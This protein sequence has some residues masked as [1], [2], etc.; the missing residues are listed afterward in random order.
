MI[1]DECLSNSQIHTST[2]GVYNL[3][4]LL[5]KPVDILFRVVFAEGQPDGAGVGRKV[6]FI[7]H[8]G[9]DAGAAGASAATTHGDAVDVEIE[10]QHVVVFDA[11]DGEAQYLVQAV[12]QIAAQAVKS[13]P[14]KTAFD[15]LHRVGFQIAQIG[16]FFMQ[17]PV[18]DPQ[19]L[20]QSDD[21]RHILRAS[22]HVALL[23]SADHQWGNGLFGV[24]VHDTDA[25]RAVKFVGRTGCSIEPGLLKIKRQ[26]SHRLHRIGVKI[27]PEF[28]AQR[29]HMLNVG[30]VA[31]L[32]VGVH[33]RN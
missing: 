23:R 8:M 13:D 10:Q 7:E 12:L 19:G 14:W 6:Q 20:R 4:Q 15:L 28:M 27:C 26:V 33:Q 22:A 24:Q 18:C 11:G 5:H 30:D 2:R 29:A 3:P 31:D 16:L 25:F 17:F 21:A 32:V 9:T 1:S